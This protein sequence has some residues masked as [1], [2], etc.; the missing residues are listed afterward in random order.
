MHQPLALAV[1]AED[2][3]ECQRDPK[4]QHEVSQASEPVDSHHSA[5]GA[6]SHC[7]CPGCWLGPPVRCTEVDILAWAVGTREDQTTFGMPGV[8]G[9]QGP[10]HRPRACT[11]NPREGRWGLH[12][13]K[14]SHTVAHLILRQPGVGAPGTCSDLSKVTQPRGYKDLNLD[15]SSQSLS[16]GRVPCGLSFPQSIAGSP[17]GGAS[18]SELGPQLCILT[19]SLGDAGLRSPK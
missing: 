16:F 11:A 17:K 2:M 9:K 18:G 13:P 14:V 10:G 8:V 1:H 5:P 4:R 6:H 7:R 12:M 3:P 15:L 19:G